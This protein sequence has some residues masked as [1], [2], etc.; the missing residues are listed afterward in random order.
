MENN[1]IKVW[2]D[3]SVSNPHIVE[4]IFIEIIDPTETNI[5]INM[6]Y[7]PNTEILA[8]IDVFS[9]TLF[10]IMDILNTEN[11]LC[12]IMNDTNSNLLNI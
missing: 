2:E 10:D 8:D 7:R 11:K 5:V 12:D 3:I 6:I 4:S 9:S 1:N